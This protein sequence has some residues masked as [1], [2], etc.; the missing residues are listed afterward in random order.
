MLRFLHWTTRAAVHTCTQEYAALK[1]GLFKATRR[2][3]GALAAYLIL[4]VD[5]EV[6]APAEQGRLC[7]LWK[8][9]LINSCQPKLVWLPLPQSLSATH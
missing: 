2:S 7:R 3:G 9:A 6:R 8:Q 1:E 5:G 4:T